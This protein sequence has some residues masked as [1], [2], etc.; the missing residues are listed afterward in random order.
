MLRDMQTH[1]VPHTTLRALTA[2]VTVAIV[3]LLLAP[4]VVA[5]SSGLVIETDVTFNDPAPATGTFEVTAGA[6]QL[7]CRSGTFVDEAGAGNEGSPMLADGGWSYLLRRTKVMTCAS[8][9]AS[10]TISVQFG[11]DDG[12]LADIAQGAGSWQIVGGTG[13]FASARGDGV[14]AVGF[15]GSSDANETFT[16]SVDVAPP[17]AE[18]AFTGSRSEAAAVV[19]AVALA[20]GAALLAVEAFL[21]R[22]VRW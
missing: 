19:G 6:E 9:P 16:G 5:Q 3:L 10:G 2:G 4:P 7:G 20:A 8:G 13:D 15:A 1:T 22:L 21:A 11:V 18:L 12:A 14:L 17:P